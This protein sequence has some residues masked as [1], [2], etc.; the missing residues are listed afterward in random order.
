MNHNLGGG[1]GHLLLFSGRAMVL[2]VDWFKKVKII[3]DMNLCETYFPASF[4]HSEQYEANQILEK[5][6]HITENGAYGKLVFLTP[7]CLFFFWRGGV[8]L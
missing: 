4:S 6:G 2:L 3:K 7:L 8:C 5:Y 1:G